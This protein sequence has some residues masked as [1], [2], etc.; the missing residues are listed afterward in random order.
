MYVDSP[1]EV[2]PRHG[3]FVLLDQ[4]LRECAAE[5]KC[6]GPLEDC[7]L[8]A[9]FSGADFGPVDNPGTGHTGK[10]EG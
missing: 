2:C 5:H 3:C 8:K 4:A 1:L 7:P 10:R 6:T 9:Y